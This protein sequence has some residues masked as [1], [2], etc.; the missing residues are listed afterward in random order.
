[1]FMLNLFKRADQE[2]SRGADITARELLEGGRRDLLSRLE[3]QPRLQAELLQGIGTI[4][5]GMGEYVNA[6]STFAD[7]ARIYAQLGMPRETTMA[8]AAHADNALRAGDPKRALSLLQQAKDVPN[9]PKTDPELNARLTEVEGWIANVQGRA[10]QARALFIESR[11]EATTA[12][13]P[14]HVQTMEALR[15]LIFAERLSRNFEEALAL[16]RQLEVATTK[17]IGLDPKEFAKSDLERAELLYAAGHYSE[18]LSHVL[19]ALPHCAKALGSNEERCRRLLLGKMQFMLRLGMTQR[20][21]EEVPLVDALSEDRTSPTLQAEAL[22]L[23]FR[24]ESALGTSPRQRALFERVRTFGE[25]GSEVPVNPTLK[26]RALLALAESRLLSGDPSGAQQ[27]VMRASTLQRSDSGGTTAIVLGAVSKSLMGVALLQSARQDEALKQLRR[28]QGELS[29][30]LG[31]EHP[32]PQLVSL[33][34]AL[35]L[36]ALGRTED[37]VALVVVADPILRKSMGADAPTYLR[38]LKLKARLQRKMLKRESASNGRPSE[39]S[40]LLPHQA[41]SLDFFS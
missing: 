27:W 39:N 38:V 24:L 3:G 1:D 30:V 11:R 33:N 16:Q 19:A 18:G 26:A 17:T 8:R 13:G 5:M 23:T 34:I 9:R 2:K 28:A 7:A 32:L 21:Q 15:G 20:A 40:T 6:D 10:E 25:S 35:A 4:Q 12:F 29:E 14:Y 41:P 37:A 36:D 31:A 22:F